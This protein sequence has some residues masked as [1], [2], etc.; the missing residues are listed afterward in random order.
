MKYLQILN[1][2]VLITGAAMAINLAVVCL[3][4]GVHVDSEP[5]LAA[6]LPR[7][8]AITALFAGL[9][10][11]GAGAFFGQRRQWTARWLLQAVPLL[12]AL[13]LVAFL[14]GLRS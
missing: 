4:Y 12:P 13:G 14:A 10:L 11:A 6:D 5:R 9:G 2:A 7:L 8:Y 3:L 1:A